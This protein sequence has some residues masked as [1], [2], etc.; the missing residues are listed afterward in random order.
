MYGACRVCPNRGDGVRY[1]LRAGR[2]A[3]L[4]VRSKLTLARRAAVCPFFLRSPLFLSSIDLLQLG[5]AGDFLGLGL[6]LGKG[7][8]EDSGA[9]GLHRVFESAG[10]VVFKDDPVRLHPNQTKHLHVV[11]CL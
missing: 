4:E 7:W 1:S 3:I 9:D 6:G 2:H 11:S 10:G 8:E 5:I